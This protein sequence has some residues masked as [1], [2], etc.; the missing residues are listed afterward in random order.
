MYLELGHLP[1]HKLARFSNEQKTAVSSACNSRLQTSK[2]VEQERFLDY[3]AR[4]TAQKQSALYQ[5]NTPVASTYQA[6]AVGANGINSQK[7]STPVA[8]KDKLLSSA[9]KEILTDEIKQAGPNSVYNFAPPPMTSRRPR[10]LSEDTLNCAPPRSDF[11]YEDTSQGAR[12]IKDALGRVL[13]VKSPRDVALSYTYDHA[14]RLVYWMKT[15]GAGHVHSIGECVYDNLLDNKD[16]IVTVRDGMGRIISQGHS[17]SVAPDGTLTV[18]RLDGQY[19]SIDIIRELAIERRAIERSDVNWNFVTALMAD[20]GF[21][22]SSKFQALHT[23]DTTKFRFYGRDGSVVQFDSE[24][25]LLAKRPNNA[26]PAGSRDIHEQ[27]LYSE[28]KKARTAWDA[29]YEYFPLFASGMN[30]KI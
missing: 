16:R 18:R 12:I 21:R 27:F 11:R 22:L 9:L 26:Y 3:L 23:N 6:P 17:A 14:G 2:E 1:R 7:I 15:D 5:D 30:S 29:V 8:A 20:D 24:D 4:N 13:Y 25:A 10:A 19:W 28:G